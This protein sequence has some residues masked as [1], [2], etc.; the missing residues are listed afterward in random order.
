M[1]TVSKHRSGLTLGFLL[2]AAVGAAAGVL[3]APRSGRA[4][5]QRWQSTL[6]NSAAQLPETA[7]RLRRTVR[8]RTVVL[9]AQARGRWSK[10]LAHLRQA[11]AQGLAAAQLPPDDA[12]K[13]A[14]GMAAPSK[15]APPPKQKPRQLAYNRIATAATN[16]GD[17]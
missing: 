9:S 2:G 1:A 6:R 17:R 11:L 16:V 14:G 13:M 8:D 4:T 12:D 10:R 15:T 5:R 7:D 3:L